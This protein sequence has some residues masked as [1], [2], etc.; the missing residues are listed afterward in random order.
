MTQYPAESP[1]VGDEGAAA[2]PART[3]S[4]DRKRRRRAAGDTHNTVRVEADAIVE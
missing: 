4:P 3:P 1:L 2:A